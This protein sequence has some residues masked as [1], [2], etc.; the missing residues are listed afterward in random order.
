MRLATTAV[1]NVLRSGLS[2]VTGLIVARSLGA[3]GYGDLNFLLGSFTAFT[4]LLDMGTT[5]GFYTLIS[6]R[7]RPP[8]FFATYFAYTI[9][10]Q[11]LLTLGVIAWILPPR[12]IDAVWVHHPKQAV[13][14]A[15]AA[16][17]FVSQIFAAVLQ[18]GEATR[19]TVIAQTASVCQA[20]LHLVLIFGLSLTGLLTVKAVLLLLA[21][22][23][24]LVA[25]TVG[26]R[27]L[28]EN[29]SRDPADAMAPSDVVRLFAK[30]CAPLA[31]LGVV[32]SLYIFA[33]R[34]L[35][36]KYGGSV[37]QGYFAI[38]QQLAT[39]S[40]IAAASVLN[41]LWK[42]VSEANERGDHERVHHLYRQVRRSLFSL[43]AF[44]SC[45]FPLYSRE[46]LFV[47]VGRDYMKGALTVAILSIF[48]IHQAMGQLQSAMFYGTGE[49][50]AYGL[51]GVVS[52]LASIVPMYFVLASRDSVVPG[53]AMGSVGLAVVTVT[54]QFIT[55]N[56]AGYLL[57]VRNRWKTA[58]FLSEVALILLMLGIAAATRG[59]M[60]LIVPDV[61][62]TTSAVIVVVVGGVLYTLAA[63]VLA[64]TV[65]YFGVERDAV[66]RFLKREAPRTA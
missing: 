41:V 54:T 43:V 12:A 31:V 21:I 8:S 49:T 40:F 2:F 66:R 64:M 58:F 11:F 23:M 15:C 59:L 9:G 65:P 16:N 63:A 6:A 37:Q 39:I 45:F 35:L 14:L 42:E 19:K 61:S 34:W 52:M 44:L 5:V 25:V 4:F 33:N 24:A 7:K 47:T 48:P 1:S 50:R 10:V 51:Y 20:A 13:L 18:L 26:P 30:F 56:A 38:G 27:L 28:R 57:A 46:I 36:Q 17:F 62:T 3:G 55:V 60:A 22:E 53:L 29:I 32:N